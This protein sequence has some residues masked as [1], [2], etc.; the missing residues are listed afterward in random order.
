MATAERLDVK[1]S[2]DFFILEELEARDF[3]CIERYIRLAGT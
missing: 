2:Q 3:P 1:E